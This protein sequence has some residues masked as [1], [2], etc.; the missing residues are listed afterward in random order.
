MTLE[1]MALKDVMMYK[2][3]QPAE[4]IVSKK[5]AAVE[6]LEKWDASLLLFNNALQLQDFDW[7][8]AYDRQ[9]KINR[10]DMF[11]KVEEEALLQAWTDS[12]L[13]QYLWLDLLLYDHAV[14]WH[15]RQVARYGLE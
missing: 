15:D 4:E 2:L 3:L 1:Y 7:P 12:E 10:D 6:I 5:Y 13:K 14:R 8:T 9:G 11:R